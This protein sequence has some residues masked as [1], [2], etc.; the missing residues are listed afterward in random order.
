[1][2]V[3]VISDPHLSF[4]VDKPMD[5]FTGWENYEDRFANNWRAVVSGDDSVIIPGDISW[6]MSAQEAVP[7]LLFLDDLP[8]KKYILKGNHD[9]WWP[10]SKKLN[11]LFNDNNITSIR[12]IYRNAYLVEGRAICGTRSWFYDSN[13]PKEK[14]FLRELMRLEASLQSGTELN[15]E[16]I[17]AFLH[18]P[19]IFSGMIVDEV[20]TLLKKYS[21]KRCFYGHIHGKNIFSAFNGEYEGIKFKLVSADALSFIPLKLDLGK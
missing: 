9:L 12:Y 2:A 17:I 19:P 13:E 10:T 20:I 5:V 6:A 15:A 1:M 7:D 21:V 18:Y 4:G 11:S 8:G 3:F 16:E 14:V